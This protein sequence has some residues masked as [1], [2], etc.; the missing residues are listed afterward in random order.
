MPGEYFSNT[1]NS[2]PQ[3]AAQPY[4]AGY[5][6]SSESFDQFGGYNLGAQPIPGGYEYTSVLPQSYANY[7]PVPQQQPQMAY[8]YGYI[9]TPA[10]YYIGR[11]QVYDSNNSP[12]E[13]IRLVQRRKSNGKRKC[14]F[15]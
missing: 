2:Q 3:Y 15:L 8:N 4:G 5:D 12:D 13:S 7:Y 14:F 10:N 6:Y 1:Y 11:N 9:E